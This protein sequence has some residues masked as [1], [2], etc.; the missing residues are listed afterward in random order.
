MRKVFLVCGGLALATC[1]A[2]AA[3]SVR[4]SLVGARTTPSAGQPWTARLTVR[5]RSFRGV[6]QVTARGPG[7]LSAP[8]KPTRCS[9]RARL[10]FPA[11]GRW[12]LT[13]RAGGSTSRL[14]S[15][16]VRRSAL[17]FTWPTSVDDQPDGSLLV[18]EN[19]RARMLVV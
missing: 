6:V 4:V 2:L 13:A 9:Y 12:T 19:G 18:V 10:V 15:V 1:T 17:R 14:G 7:R 8:E 5:P 16:T 3:E 11:A